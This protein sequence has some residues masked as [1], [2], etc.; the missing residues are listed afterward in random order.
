MNV[1]V[2]AT[3]WKT[4][5]DRLRRLREVVFIE[6]QGVS[7]EE[8]W[9]GLDDDAQHF[10]A[11]DSA[12]QAIGT[13]RLLDHGQ[14]GRM[15]VLASH[16]G[17]GIG[18]RLLAAAIDAAKSRGMESVHLHAQ[19]HAI[20]FYRKAG[21]DPVGEEFMEAGIPHT[22]MRL[23]LPV[24][25]TGSQDQRSLA[26]VNPEGPGTAPDL[27]PKLVTFDTESTGRQALH[28]ILGNARRELV[29]ASPSLDRVMFGTPESV[30]IVST[31]VRRAAIPRVRVLIEDARSI[32]GTGHPLLQLA[33][34]LPSK[35][36]L[37]RQ[38]PDVPE[39]TPVSY[40]VADDEGLWVMPDRDKPIGFANAH[41]RVE[42]RRLL[43]VFNRLFDR[44]VDEPE[45]R[46]FSL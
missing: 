40:V 31:F 46:Q 36:T 17:S 33:Q 14:I 18:M 5:G 43:E 41:D 44:A 4:H 24:E 35:I 26:I 9:D 22:E 2:T 42:A 45:L 6:E 38:P 8:E 29:I 12:G 19:V 34:R 11:L 7:R 30:D 10:I 15:A 3:D 21:F 28:R 1:Y 39:G 37:R 32:A 25:F 16:R 27:A 13:A 23:L 20:P